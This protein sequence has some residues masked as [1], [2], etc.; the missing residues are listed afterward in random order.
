[1]APAPAQQGLHGSLMSRSEQLSD[2]ASTL[3]LGERLGRAC[4]AQALIYI[5]GELG[6]GKTTMV[7]GILRALGHAGLVKSPTYTLVE[8]YRCGGRE[9]YHFD[10]YRLADPEELELMGARDYFED[11]AIC[12]VEWPERG[13]GILPEPDLWLNLAYRDD[14]R[15]VTLTAATERGRWVLEKI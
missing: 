1:M 3:S 11:D 10:L 2:E 8:P 14:G 6:A 15:D 12:L 7:R 5:R 4:G 13:E 9:V